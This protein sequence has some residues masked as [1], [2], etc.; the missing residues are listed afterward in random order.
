MEYIQGRTLSKI[1]K[2]ETLGYTKIAKWMV[3]IAEAIQV[4]HKHGIIH[5]DLKPANV[6]IDANGEPKVMDFGL[7]K[8]VE[9]DSQLSHDN[10]IIGTP[11]YMPPEQAEGITS[12][13]D[14]HSDI[15]SLGAI[16]YELLTG[17]PPF[18]A[19]GSIAII[20]KVIEQDPIVPR[21]LKPSIP[22]DLESICL[23]CLEKKTENRYLSARLLAKDLQNFLDNKPIIAKPIGTIG[24]TY[25]WC[26][27][28]PLATFFL[29]LTILSNIISLIFFYQATQARNELAGQAQQLLQKNREVKLQKQ[30]AEKARYES[31]Q[32]LKLA[33]Q[34][35]RDAQASLAISLVS[36]G[37]AFQLT[38]S[39]AK[40]KDCYYKSYDLLTELGS[41]LGPASFGLYQV[42]LTSPPSIRR[43]QGERH[44]KEGWWLSEAIAFSEDGKYIV[45]GS[46]N[47][48]IKVWE[49]T[50]GQNTLTLNSGNWI[51][52]ICYSPSGKFI[53]SAGFDSI[54]SSKKGRLML[55]DAKTG[56]LLRRFGNLDYAISQAVYIPGNDYHAITI[57]VDG[58]LALWDLATDAPPHKNRQN[59]KKS[60]LCLGI[61][62][63]GKRV[64]T[65]DEAGNVHLW[66]V[67]SFK[68]NIFL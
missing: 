38:Q 42:Y 36:Q 58:T 47:G 3:K 24:R 63:D 19:G 22:P 20:I 18:Q 34:K 28:Y 55:W 62:K 45:A 44:M 48:F 5:R 8:E 37:S 11:A 30:E 13:I 21:K 50:S 68:R 17:N 16:L 52:S 6:M 14:K 1:I 64:A 27:R 25:K 54:T 39:W 4:A 60:S 15:Y 53:L 41:S 43:F 12:K 66:Q 26:R 57:A 7:A 46:R 29:A 31:E 23:K 9:S 67:P 10:A 49:V 59:N 51:E 65:G 40:A 35:T 2:E 32:N 33:K 56:K 61:S